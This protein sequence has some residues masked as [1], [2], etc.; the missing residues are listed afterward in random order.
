MFSLILVAAGLNNWLVGDVRM[1]VEE[2]RSIVVT[3]QV[4]EL[5]EATL[6]LCHR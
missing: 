4:C 1:N 6:A 2:K 5:M 3:Q